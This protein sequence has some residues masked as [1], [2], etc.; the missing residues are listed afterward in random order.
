MNILFVLEYYPPHVGGV[1]TVFENICQ[2]LTNRGHDVT[3][4][5]SKLRGTRNFETVN[6]VK[7]YRVAVPNRY[8]FTLLSI[9]KVYKLAGEADLIHTTTYNGAFPAWSVSKLRGKKCVITVHEV[10]GSSWK[11]LEGMNWFTSGLHKF[12]EKLVISLPFDKYACVS[13]NTYDS[14]SMAIARDDRLEVIYNAVDGDLFNPEKA[15][16]DKIRGKLGVSSCFLYTYYGRPGISKGVEYLIQAVPLISQKLPGSK[17]LLI[18]AKDPEDR[19]ENIQ[20]MIKDLNIKDNIIL[21]DPVTRFELPDYIAASDCVVVPS[22]SE[23][24]GFVAA[25]A[26]SMGK[27]VVASD[28]GALPEVIY[29][30][31]VFVEPRNPAAIAEGVERTYKGEGDYKEKRVFSWDD[32]VENYLKVYQE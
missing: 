28:V 31:H 26:C 29:G 21:M 14:L 6:N 3:V 16:R 24:F 15:D 4:V 30:T 11:E 7:I 22:L 17:L 8:V 27:P 23:G 25:E 5:T 32:C 13:K 20:N 1:E 2:G 9:P 12:L 10:L 18:L 19:Y